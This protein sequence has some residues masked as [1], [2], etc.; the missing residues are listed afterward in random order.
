MQVADL[1][2]YYIQFMGKLSL[3]I[4]GRIVEIYYP[5]YISGMYKVHW[6][7]VFIGYIYVRTVDVHL[8]TRVWAG[9]TPYVDLYLNE[10]GD[11]IESSNI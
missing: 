7:K 5:T 6:D 8:G 4:E 9:T 10:I 1:G 3:I 2:R 11:L